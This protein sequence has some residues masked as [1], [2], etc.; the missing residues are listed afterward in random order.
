M[1]RAYIQERVHTASSDTDD[2]VFDDRVGPGQVL[3]IQ[4]LCVTWSGMA[5][6]EEAHFFVED[7][8][9]RIFLGEDA[10]IDAGGH[11]HFSGGVTIGEGDRVGVYCPDIATNDEVHFYIVGE[12]W[13]LAQWR[14]KRAE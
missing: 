6:E 11:P 4:N 8:G 1:R 14:G 2:Y 5:S 3:V 13:D 9:R 12:V 7:S 10:P